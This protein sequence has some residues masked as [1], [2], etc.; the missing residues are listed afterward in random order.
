[1]EIQEVQN[2]YLFGGRGFSSNVF[3]C[4]DYINDKCAVCRAFC[5]LQ[6]YATVFSITQRFLTL[7]PSS[8][9]CFSHLP[10]P[11]CPSPTP[12]QPETSLSAVILLSQFFHKKEVRFWMLFLFFQLLKSFQTAFCSFRNI[13]YRYFPLFNPFTF[14]HLF[15]T[16][17]SFVTLVLFFKMEAVMT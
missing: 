17:F 5:V 13:I 15:F 14:V 2:L 1:M 10:H 9:P 7:L 3:I 16:S 4:I 12:F 11:S 8:S 6:I